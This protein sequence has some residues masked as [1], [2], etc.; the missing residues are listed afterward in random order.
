MGEDVRNLIAGVFLIVFIFPR[1]GQAKTGGVVKTQEP[2]WSE[3]K[4][5]KP[6]YLQSGEAT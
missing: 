3:E 5:S 4:L 2:V 1:D 6:V